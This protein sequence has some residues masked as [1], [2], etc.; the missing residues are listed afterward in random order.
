M[1]KVP[2]GHAR[3]EEALFFDALAEGRLVFQVCDDCGAAV[4]YL[5]TVCPHCMSARLR[6]ESSAGLGTVHSLT[7]LY[8][9][10]DPARREDVP[11]SIAL[12]DL[13]EGVRLIGDLSADAAALG[14]DARVRA[15]PAAGGVSFA[16]AGH[17]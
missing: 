9:A 14:I 3:G 1:A 2:V 13:D 7:T 10:G 17:A 5:R 12:V 15:L 6:L 4:W 16:P 11:Y 8:R